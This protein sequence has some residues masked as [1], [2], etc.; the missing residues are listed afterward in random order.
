MCNRKEDAHE[1]E[2][3]WELLRGTREARLPRVSVEESLFHI[4]DTVGNG[5]SRYS[6]ALSEM[7]ESTPEVRCKIQHVVVA[8]ALAL[9]CGSIVYS[10]GYLPW[11][12]ELRIPSHLQLH[13]PDAKA[14]VL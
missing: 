8:H 14:L 13:V 3:V 7:R 12:G 1:M 9:A 11:S 6:E 5:Y 2:V 10:H 4:G